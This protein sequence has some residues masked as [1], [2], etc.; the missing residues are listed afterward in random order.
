[1]FTT[2]LL[3]LSL[4]AAA[5]DHWIESTLQD[6]ALTLQ[7]RLGEHLADAEPYVVRE[8]GRYAR[9]DLVDARG[10]VSL[11][12][13]LLVGS[14]PAV[15]VKL[16]PGTSGTRM[17]VADAQP[18]DIELEGA[19][20]DGYLAEEGLSQVRAARAA[21]GA[22]AAPARERYTRH[23][24]HLF[25]SG[26]PTPGVAER[27]LGQA[28]EIVPDTDPFTLAEGGALS[29]RVLFQGQPL[30]DTPVLGARRAPDGTVVS[31]PLRTDAEGRV[32]LAVAGKGIWIVR[33]V[34]MLPSTE[35]AAD[36]RSWWASLTFA[37]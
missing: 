33:L 25:T 17:V 32:R 35:P 31:Y 15:V 10:V 14:D 3:S 13:S 16:A 18:R 12:S 19:K 6:R 24:K 8:P 21:A 36:W 30:T 28:L 23:L 37:S 26:T 5:H 1:M 22:T 9:L 7:L 34:H 29:L 27:V 11:L 2:L 20:F 4:S